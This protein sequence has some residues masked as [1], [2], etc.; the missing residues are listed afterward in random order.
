MSKK[1]TN[2]KK[3]QVSDCKRFSLT[4]PDHD[5]PVVVP[6]VPSMDDLPRSQR[7]RLRNVLTDS[8]ADQVVN[9]GPKFQIGVDYAIA[10]AASQGVRVDLEGI[11][12]DAAYD[13]VRMEL[14]TAG[15]RLIG[16]FAGVQSGDSG[17]ATL[18]DEDAAAEA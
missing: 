18:N 1:K 7:R 2:N 12:D 6:V 11:E 14:L 4:L 10:Y 13:T 8:G 9:N 17:K 5:E 15:L 16:H 3:T